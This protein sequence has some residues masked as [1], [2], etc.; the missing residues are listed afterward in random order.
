MVTR[1]V[2]ALPVQAPVHFTNF[3][4]AWGAAV[5]VTLVP[6]ATVRVHWGPQLWPL[7]AL[8][9][10]PVPP[11]WLTVRTVSDMAVTNFCCQSALPT[12]PVVV[13]WVA[14][15]GA[16]IGA[17]NGA[18][19]AKSSVARAVCW[20]D[21]YKELGTRFPAPVAPDS[22]GGRDGFLEY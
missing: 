5:K 16:A 17:G 14:M 10:M 20:L 8:V 6:A 19:S 15:I 3:A 21:S 11:R 22:R 1:Q 12:P 9:T 18:A 4:L 7:G 13:S 2:N